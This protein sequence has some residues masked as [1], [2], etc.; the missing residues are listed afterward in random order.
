M[1]SPFDNLNDEQIL[2]L[3]RE[4]SK[5]GGEEKPKSEPLRVTLG[6]G[7]ILEAATQE[8][9]NKAIQA[10]FEEA[11]RS[12]RREEPAKDPA[13]GQAP[14]PKWD[15]DTFVKKFTTDPREGMEYYEVSNYGMPVG[16]AVPQMLAGM[17]ALAQKVQELEAT[18]YAPKVDEERRAVEQVMRER[19]WQPSRQSFQDA[20][21]IAQGSGL[22]KSKE[23]SRTEPT[24]T[25]IP[26]RVPRVSTE[27]PGTND[28]EVLRAA[29][30][31]ELE[32]L[33]DILVRAGKLKS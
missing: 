11:V 4:V 19:N 15:M 3:V 26:P 28:A 9:L 29:E 17:V 21:L 33:H 14:A 5:E 23:E 18:N 24:Q 12:S 22:L 13:T 10:K 31:M 25:F 2:A 8:D 32:Q 6:D 1:A 30:T 16:R 27:E 7:S 20:L